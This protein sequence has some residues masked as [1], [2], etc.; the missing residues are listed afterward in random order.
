MLID[1]SSSIGGGS[2]GGGGSNGSSGSGGSGGQQMPLLECLRDAAVAS[3]LGRNALDDL[4]SALP[5]VDLEAVIANRTQGGTGEAQFL[6][7]L[8]L[9]SG[10]GRNALDY[11]SALPGVDLEAVVVNRPDPRGAR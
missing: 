2:S 7:F 11:L 9:A 8:L 5:G 6:C 10:L 4:L 1:S 3:G